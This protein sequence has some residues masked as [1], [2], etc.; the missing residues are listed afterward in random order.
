MN[1]LL[2]LKPSDRTPGHVV[3]IEDRERTYYFLR[4]KY[5]TDYCPG[6]FFARV[7]DEYRLSTEIVQR[8]RMVD[9]AGLCT[10]PI[11]VYELVEKFAPGSPS[12]RDAEHPE[13]LV[14]LRKLT[15]SNRREVRRQAGIRS[16]GR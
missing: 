1:W 9:V 14:R 5:L 4:V 7:A 10:A 3:G 6:F 15:W 16:R 12:R 13:I 2:Q 8:R 11:H